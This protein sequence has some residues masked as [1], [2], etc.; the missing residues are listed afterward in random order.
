MHMNFNVTI[1]P[2]L[3]QWIYAVG[4]WNWNSLHSWG[5]YFWIYQPNWPHCAWVTNWN[6]EFVALPDTDLSKFTTG[7]AR[8]PLFNQQS[9]SNHIQHHWQSVELNSHD[10]ILGSSSWILLQSTC[11]QSVMCLWGL[12]GCLDRPCQGLLTPEP[13]NTGW[14]QV[15]AAQVEFQYSFLRSTPSHFTLVSCKPS[16]SHPWAISTWVEKSQPCSEAECS[17]TKG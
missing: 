10:K 17:S 11:Y 8:N 2:P 9:G 16:L 14:T 12:T 5:S 4:P 7:R 1:I 13:L 6:G 15:M 3:F